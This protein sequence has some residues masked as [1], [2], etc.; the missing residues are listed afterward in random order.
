VGTGGNLWYTFTGKCTL[1]CPRFSGSYSWAH[2][3]ASGK[4][5]VPPQPLAVKPSES[6]WRF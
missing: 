2:D 3:L 4:R 6:N 5:P 1:R